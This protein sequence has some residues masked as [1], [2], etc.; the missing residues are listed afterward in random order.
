M[1]ATLYPIAVPRAYRD[2]AADY[3]TVYPRP[4]MHPPYAR[5]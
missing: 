5:S 3:S 1:G 2:A 4:V